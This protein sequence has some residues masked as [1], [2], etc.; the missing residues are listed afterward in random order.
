[1]SSH[2]NANVTVQAAVNGGDLSLT[3]GQAEPDSEL[4]SLVM[5][6]VPGHGRQSNPLKELQAYVL[7]GIYCGFK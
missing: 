5:L 2:W 6:L 3:N 1:M 4:E 7:A